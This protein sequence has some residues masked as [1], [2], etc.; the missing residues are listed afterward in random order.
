MHIYDLKTNHIKNPLGYQMNRVTFSWKTN[1]VAGKK[2]KAAR[3]MVALDE[4]MEK[5]I[6]DSDYDESA[7]SVAYDADIKLSAR[8]RYYWKVYVITD[9]GETGESGISWFETGKRDEPWKA[10]WIGCDSKEERHPVF[11]KALYLNKKVL[12]ARLYICG[13]GLYEASLNGVKIGDEFLTPYFNAYRE[14]IQYQTYDITELLKESSEK[15]VLSV[16]MGNGWYIWKRAGRPDGNKNENGYKLLAEIRLLYEDGN[17]EVIGTD[18]TWQMKRSRIIMSN[19]FDGEHEDASLP[20]LPPEKAK[21]CSPPEGRLTERYSIPVQEHEKFIPVEIIHTPS[22]DTIVD[23]GQEISGTF[24]LHVDLPKGSRVLVQTGEVL[25]NGEFYRDNLRSAKSEYIY[26]SNGTSTEV[27]PRFTYYGYRYARVE[28]IPELK[29]EDFTGIALYSS[30][31]KTGTIETGHKLVNQLISNVEWSMKD[32]FVDVPTDC[33]QRD[34]RQGW[35]GDAQVFCGTAM[36]LADTYAFYRKYLHDIAQ[37]QK[38]R[39]GMVP[40]VIPYNIPLFGQMSSSAAWGDAAVII[41]WNLFQMYGDI[42][43]LREQYDSMKAWVDYVASVD[44]DDH[45]WRK[46]FQYGDWLALDSISG[47]KEDSFGGTDE[48]YIASI[49][50]ASSAETVAKAAAVLGKDKDEKK[51]RELAQRQWSD[52]KKEYFSQTGRC[53]ADTQT[54]LLLALK[55]HLSDNVEG[56]RQRL[57]FLFEKCRNTLR[58][59]FVGTPILCKILS[60]NG[61][62]DIAYRLL[63]HEEAPGWLNEVKLGATTVWER[64]DSLDREGK[65]TGTGMNSLNHY[66]YG[67]ILEWL[68]G[69]AAGIKI[70]D[71]QAQTSNTRFYKND[72][73]DAQS[74]VEN[75]GARYVRIEPA[76]NWRL[77]RVCA[78]C[79][80]PSGDYMSAWELTDPQHVKI[81]VKIPFNCEADLILPQAG[82]NVFMDKSNPLFTNVGQGVCHLDAGEYEVEYMLCEPLAKKLTIDSTIR[83]IVENPEAVKVLRPYM[84]IDAAGSALYDKT[85]RGILSVLDRMNPGIG[86]EEN[87]NRMNSLLEQC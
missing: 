38:G 82:E 30:I 57:R 55:Y 63:L 20:E 70:G 41:P 60:E 67:S 37:E 68:F 85:L 80:T 75:T 83:D 24:R 11:E 64:W 16:Q 35:T 50:F 19:I 61:M 73:F 69:Y 34:E 25:Q 43:I 18:E 53:C 72:P 29:K 15:K 78:E 10:E 6:Y 77:R 27:M 8:T 76:L 5:V 81:K 62:E 21:L 42:Q 31:E 32:N 54:G 3:I 51:Y 1:H 26:I 17:E 65:I 84:P 36:Y 7:N 12:K 48:G 22:G 66:S 9:L 14:W 87:L 23:L 86:D 71:I 47:V 58:T 49:Y 74:I 40:D 44:G 56:I 79:K 39:G 59:G 2:Q 4:E 45:G 13:L 52:L 46:A 28:G 33:P